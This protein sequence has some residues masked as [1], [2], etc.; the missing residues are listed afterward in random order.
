MRLG[1]DVVRCVYAG[2]TGPALFVAATLFMH[3]VQPELSVLNDAVSYYM[4]GPFGWVLGFGLIAIGTGSLALWLAVRRVHLKSA[5]GQAA[6]VVWAIGAIVGG[7]FPP[8]PRGS[9]DKPP[10]I[11]G[12]I[13]A[14]TAMVALLALPVAA[15]LLSKR[16]AATSGSRAIQRALRA[17]GIASLA[18]AVIFFASLAPVF[19]GGPPYLLGLSERVLLLVYVAWLTVAALAVRGCLRPEER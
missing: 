13:H 3:G 12:M 14:N 2:M 7:I 16:I 1:K 19:A 5:A 10:S 8:D 15:L 18:T 11:S 9:W 4:N 6:L 17:L